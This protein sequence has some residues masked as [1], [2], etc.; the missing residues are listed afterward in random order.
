MTSGIMILAAAFAVA[1]LGFFASS[2]ATPED[3][4]LLGL[5]RLGSAMLAVSVLG[6]AAGVW[7]EVSD[8]R[9]VFLGGSHPS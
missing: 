1:V 6:F 3:R 7:K 9:V 5:T 4:G 2:L 8:A